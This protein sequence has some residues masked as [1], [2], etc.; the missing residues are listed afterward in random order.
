M[1]VIRA[2]RASI[3]SA[4]RAERE[5]GLENDSDDRQMFSAN[6]RRA[7]LGGGIRLPRGDGE[8]NKLPPDLCPI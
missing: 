3:E 7:N 2:R 8:F 5:R 4:T 1:I 6:A